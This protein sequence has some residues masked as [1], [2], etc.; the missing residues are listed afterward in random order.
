MKIGFVV[1]S[2]HSDENRPNG[3]QFIDK[4]CSTL[5][6]YCHYPF[7]LYV[8]DNGSTYELTLPENAINI[9]IDNQI[10]EGITGAWNRGIY[11]AYKDGCDLI[12]NCSDDQ[13]FNETINSFIHL[14]IIHY[15]NF[16]IAG[17]KLSEDIIYGPLTNGVLP[18]CTQKSDKPTS[19][20]QIKSC[21]DWNSVISGFCFAMTKEHYEK[22][23]FETDKYFNQNNKHNGDDGKWAGQEGQFLENSEKGLIGLVVNECWLPH[24]K[25]RGWTRMVG[26]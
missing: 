21:G 6:E 10:K 25:E 12:I 7:N 5:N 19:G 3:G 1:T 23:R 16:P 20:V 18:P 2:H 24:A 17:E 22:Y 4:F 14:I 8:M 11:R 9:R 26:K 15:N 13:W